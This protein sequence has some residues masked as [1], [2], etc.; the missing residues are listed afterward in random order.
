MEHAA[1]LV[2][3]PFRL[4]PGQKRLWRGEKELALQPRPVAVLLYLVEH[5]GR[6]VTK[7]ELLKAVWA[8]TYVT[9]AALKVCVRAI[10]V[11]LG[12][13]AAAPQYVETVGREGYRFIARV[14]GSPVHG[15]SFPSDPPPSF[16]VHASLVVGRE[17]EVEQLQGWLAKA[18]RGVRQVVF[19]TGE[20][21]IGKTTVVERFLQQVHARGPVWLGRGQCV[22]QYGEGEAYLPVLEALGQVCRGPG[23]KQVIALLRQSA[24]MWLVQMPAL[25]SEAELEVLQR[26]VAGAT[27]ERMLREMAEAVEALTAE[28]GLV[29]VFED[30][31][32]SDHSTLELIAYLARRPEPVRLMVIGTY[33]P[34]DVVVQEHPLKGLKQELHV[35]GYCEEIRLELLTEEDVAAYVAGRFAA[36]A[37]ASVPELARLIYRRT[38]GN[39]LFMVNLVND[40]VAQHVMVH[41]EGRWELSGTI[42]EIEREIPAS[43]RQFIEQQIERLNPQ[44]QEV[45]AVA[46]VAGME[47]SAAAVAA[48]LAAAVAEGEKR[49][50]EL[51]RRG[52]FLRQ[53]GIAE[54]PDGTVASRYSFLHT[55]YHE[56]LYARVT[57]AW[58]AHL[59]QQIGQREEAGYGQRVG[60][61]A[62]ELAVHFA[63]GR[64]Y[65]RAV[66]YLQGAGENAIRRSAYQ[67]AAA[68]CMKGLALL[69]LLPETP[70]RLQQELLLQTTLG[71]A[72]VAAKGQAAPE[73]GQT[74]TRALELCRQIGE[75]PQL[76]LVLLGLRRFYLVRAELQTARELGEQLLSLA[77]SVQDPSLLLE[78]HGALGLPLF[79]L[80]ELASAR[81]HL[82]QGIA[83]YEPQQH[84]SHIF[85][86]GQDPGVLCR[87]YGAF[88]LW[89]LGY[90]DQALQRIQE[91]LILAQE[92]SHP[93]SLAVALD[94]AAWLDQLCRKRQAAQE[95]AET[96]VALC[97]EQE[98]PF[99]L[100]WGTL[101][102]GWAL[103]ERG[104]GEEGITRLL[105]GLAAY[106]ATG[107][108]V[109]RPYFLALLAEAYRTVGQAEEGLSVLAEA[110]AVAHRTGERF[111]EAE[112]YRLKGELLLTRA[113]RRAKAA[114]KKGS[115]AEAEGCFQKAIT[116]AHHQRAKSLEL[117]AVMSLSRLWQQQGKQ[118][119]ARQLLAEI[120]SW[121]TEGF[122]TADLQEAKALLDALT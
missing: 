43:I 46:S 26:K 115:G 52:H 98:F 31:Q 9:R 57:G 121:F 74:Y 8:G 16:H 27:R 118:A 106:Q 1:Q 48:G 66:R 63:Q 110:L 21:G 12:D 38:D 81:A 117:R 112:L 13:A 60:E 87:V 67:E 4:D 73:V 108:E 23:G 32:W 30:L 44:D 34:T 82:E 3:G 25:V 68:Q 41:R 107:A 100:A 111:Y 55:L 47:F 56:M 40:L 95:R 89:H 116:I 83:L 93:L 24:P 49:C 53:S 36:E 17:R 10:R 7:E 59:H 99:W 104:Q 92:L 78:A 113:G 54:W 33:R 29:L 42:A 19:V 76:F 75:T 28:R 79:W 70:E 22:E 102:Q 80:G 50:A 61:I 119:E 122:D 64:D 105:Q 97:T 11:A 103:V 6:V 18:G 109:V 51:A 69:P 94:F 14:A 5:P 45:L 85:L 37:Q 120:Y 101:L 77:Q 91:A 88:A 72:L 65:P 90:P 96:A 20:A 35:H 86:Y 39:A 15:S 71:P 84:S 2:F 62:A 58:R 114:G